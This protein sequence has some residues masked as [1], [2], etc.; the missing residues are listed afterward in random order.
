M[1]KNVYRSSCKVQVIVVRLQWN[2]NFLN[3]LL[4]NTQI[5][6]FRPVGAQLLRADGRTDRKDEA[7]IVFRNFCKRV[8]KYI[9][10]SKTAIICSKVTRL[11]TSSVHHT[12]TLLPLVG[13]L[14]THSTVG[15]ADPSVSQHMT[16]CIQDFT[17]GVQY[18]YR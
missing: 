9:L 13:P 11:H 5:P 10:T 14:R 6:N 4:K 3:R 12:A 2:L 17:W 16:P 18:V 8:E 7:I 15:S 1:I